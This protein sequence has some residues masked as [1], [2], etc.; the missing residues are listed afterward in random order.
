MFPFTH[1]P[2]E[3]YLHVSFHW[4][5]IERDLFERKE[6]YKSTVYTWA[7]HYAR[8]LWGFCWRTFHTR[9]IYTSLFTHTNWKKTYLHENRSVKE[10]CIPEHCVV[11]EGCD[12]TVD[13]L[14]G[15]LFADGG[16]SVEWFNLH[17]RLYVAFAHRNNPAARCGVLQWCRV[18][19]WCSVLPW[20][21]VVQCGAVWYSMVHCG[22]VWCSVVQCGAVWY[23]VGQCVLQ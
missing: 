10:T 9:P 11:R 22:A 15:E 12:V 20:C 14:G 16:Y 2:H 8:E 4:H 17:P 5:E 21:R 1:I 23:S 13:D 19:Q 18:L 7:P 6:T 3:T